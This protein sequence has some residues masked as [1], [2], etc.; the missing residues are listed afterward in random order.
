M[1]QYNILVRYAEEQKQRNLHKRLR[2]KTN[3]INFSKLFDKVNVQH[4]RP[5]L[6]NIVSR[7]KLIIKK[8]PQNDELMLQIAINSLLV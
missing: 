7:R 5:S 3:K 8:L 2:N 4:N 1:I 6:H